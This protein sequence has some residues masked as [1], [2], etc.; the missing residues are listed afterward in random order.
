MK[1]LTKLS[2][3][4]FERVVNAQL[5]FEYDDIICRHDIKIIEDE[6]LKIEIHKKIS[7]I[8]SYKKLNEVKE[9]LEDRFGKVSEDII[10]YMHEELFEKKASEIG[11]N[12][13]RQ[14]KNFVDIILDEKITK[15]LDGETLFL[16]L[17]DLS[18]MFRFGNKFNKLVI[19]LDTVKL[20]KHFI[21]YLIDFVNI[22]KE[23]QKK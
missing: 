21:Y 14:T 4:S 9:E 20:D 18:R 7:Q 8:D 1:Y 5:L 17:N 22:L 12:N 15:N 6:D 23:C 13:I 11:I 19:T 2:P 10:I 3:S 16:K